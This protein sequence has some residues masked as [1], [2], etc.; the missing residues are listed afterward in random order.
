[1]YLLGIDL[2]T[3]SLK[4]V[5]IREDGQLLGVGTQ[6]YPILT[7]QPAWAEQEPEAWWRAAVLSVR[8]ALKRAAQAAGEPITIGGIGL[9]GQMHGF[10]LVGADHQP[11]GPAIIWPDQRS[12]EEVGEITTLIGSERLA[13]IAGTAPA[14]GFLGP[15]LRWLC[16][17]DPARLDRAQACLMPKDY[18][19]LR[20]TGNIA[21]DASDASATAIFDIGQRRW[22]D[23][24]IKA[25]ELPARLL[26]P[27]L[28]SNEVAGQ[29]TP[30]AA[31]ALGLRPG[32]PVVTGCAD[33]AAQAVGNGLIDP[34]TGSV[35]IGTG[36]Q[37]FAP[38]T[39]PAADPQLRLHTFCHAPAGRWYALGAILSAGLSLRWLRDT[40]GLRE[41]P[42]AYGQ[43]SALAAQVPPGADGLLFLPYLVGERAPL[44]DPRARGCFVGLTLRHERGHLARAIMEGVALA[45][46]QV[47]NIML[48]LN[49]VET[50]LASGN[51]LVLS[52]VWRQIVTDVFASPL[53][54]AKAGERAGV[55]AALIAG[56]GA[57]L[58]RDYAD[59]RPITGQAAAT[60]LSEPDAERAAFYLEQYKRFVQVYPLL[61]PILHDLS[62]A[63]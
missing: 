34:G 32:I 47:L 31:E 9:S 30:S 12:V 20:L 62:R 22:S 58:F 11:V 2:G 29:L 24:I 45:M 35:T 16:K 43:L 60:D 50:L 25:L 37:L 39:A 33:Q 21:T 1:M 3:S 52:P 4:A 53:R 59:L 26:P 51:G 15:T 44:M 17:H 40:L 8:E 23:E 13:R 36:G 48:E 49:P 55:G 6:E 5:V 46:R 38:L 63:S 42:D 10:A 61:K 28:E 41:T 54:L 57:G 19:R 7:P 14:T 56:I 27:V 18:V